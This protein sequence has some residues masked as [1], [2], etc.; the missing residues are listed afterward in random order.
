LESRGHAGQFSIIAFQKASYEGRFEAFGKVTVN[1]ITSFGELGVQPAVEGLDQKGRSLIVASGGLSHEIIG[2]VAVLDR[3]GTGIYGESKRNGVVKFSEVSRP[4]VRHE[5]DKSGIRDGKIAVRYQLADE[6]G[7]ESGQIFHTVVEGGQTDFEDLKTVEKITAEF[8]IL[9][10]ASQI[11]SRGSDQAGKVRG[12][13]GL[14]L[15]NEFR[16]GLWIQRGDFLQDKDPSAGSLERG[17]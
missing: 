15:P 12:S 3:P 4:V 7:N 9:R 17:V 5:L 13:P 2:K 14:N 1:W 6:V 8:S 10:Q 11:F 16:L